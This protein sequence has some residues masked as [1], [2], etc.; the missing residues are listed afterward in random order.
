VRVLNKNGAGGTSR[1]LCGIDWV[2]ATRTDND[3][4]NDIQVA[5]MSLGGKGRDDG[6]CGATRKDPLHVAICASVQAGVV[7]AVSA[8]NEGDDLAG[9]V[10]A[11]Y[12]EVLTATAMTELDGQPGGLGS[13]G[14]PGGCSASLVDAGEDVVDDK[15]VSFSNFATATSDH[16]HTLAAPGVCMLSTWRG[17]EFAEC[18]ISCY[19]YDSGTSMASPH[20]AGTVALCIASGPCAGLTPG[21]IVSKIVADAQAYNTANPGY[22]FQGD[23]LRPISGK[24]YGYLIRA[25]L[26]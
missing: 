25:G 4:D 16:A 14:A 26:Y 8:G 6:N 17:G 10:P 1:I 13:I 18:P 2:T 11:A 7:Y 21:Q 12:D 23:P 9:H 5:N 24:Y 3:P 22:G 15:A 19:R 20:I